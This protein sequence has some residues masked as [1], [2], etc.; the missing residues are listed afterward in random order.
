MASNKARVNKLMEAKMLASK[1]KD[2]PSGLAHFY[3]TIKETEA[4]FYG[5]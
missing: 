4:L 5:K 2:T 3:A 1:K